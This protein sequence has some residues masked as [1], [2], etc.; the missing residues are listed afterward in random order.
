[1]NLPF[2]VL[3]GFQLAV[4]R[5]FRVRSP[6]SHRHSVCVRHWLGGIM[7]AHAALLVLALFVLGD[8]GVAVSVPVSVI[9][10]PMP[11]MLALQCVVDRLT[12]AARA[13]LAGSAICE[14]GAGAA[15]F[16]PSICFGDGR[17]E[18]HQHRLRQARSPTRVWSRWPGIAAP[19]ASSPAPV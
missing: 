17:G 6:H 2:D 19:H 4:P 10:T 3:I 7:V 1:M 9:G 13:A 15:A 12:A 11:P 14:T 16:L 18:C 5:N 8:A